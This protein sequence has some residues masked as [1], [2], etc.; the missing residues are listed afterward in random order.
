MEGA[1]RW[2]GLASDVITRAMSSGDLLKLKF[3]GYY[4]KLVKICAA[5]F[6]AGMEYKDSGNVDKVIDM[7]INRIKDNAR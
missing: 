4:R 1:D 3:S 6:E 7:V 2:E 5:F